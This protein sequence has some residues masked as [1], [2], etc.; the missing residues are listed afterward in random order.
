MKSFLSQLRWLFSPQDKRKFIFI[1][2]LMSLS[3]L[4]ELAGLGVLLAAATVFLSPASAAGQT[5]TDF[6]DRLMPGIQ[7][8][9]RIAATIG[10]IGILLT[11]K[12]LFAFF[13]IH[14]QS[15]FVF[16]KRN[17]M[18]HRIYQKLLHADFES[19]NQLSP[20]FCFN[21]FTRSSDICYQILL[22]CMQLLADI[23]AIAILAGTSIIMFPQVTIGGIIFMLLVTGAVQFM[24]HR[25]NRR[26]GELLL[27]SS[28]E[29]NRLRQAGIAGKKTIKC[30]AKE[31]FF[32]DK[33]DYSYAKTG[34][35]SCKLYTLGQV[36]RL[37]LESAS[38]LLA[39]GV[40]ILMLSNGI[41]KAE[42]LLTFAVLTAA[43]SRI[44]PALSRGHYSLTIIRQYTPQLTVVC[45]ILQN[46]PQEQQ[47]AGE[48]ADAGEDIVFKDVSFAYKNGANVFDKLNLTIKKNS[49][50][51]IA[52]R[53]GRGKSTLIDLLLGLLIP[54]AGSITAGETAI[55]NNLPEWRKQ[56]GIVPQ[57]I[58]LLE[59]SVAENVAFGEEK[60]DIPKVI[61]ALK[62]AGLENLSPEFNITA[63]G[64]L[65]GGQRQRIGIAR[66]L[67]KDIKLLILDEATS[68]L[69]TKTESAFC[70][71]LKTLQG[72][73]TLIVISH[74]ESTLE[75]C[76]QRIDL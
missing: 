37:V 38:A 57:T 3:A 6:L 25:V 23:M 61:Y 33:F 63:Q 43:V 48:C 9:I 58:F 17:E 54:S 47:A 50:L 34:R 73:I 40:F 64:N 21:I 28:L 67:Y 31:Q 46:L 29:E 59:A 74:R 70:D 12:N 24:T 42:I 13:I 39:C 8:D 41:P 30:A 72:K 2:M 7:P 11:A 22:P 15:R 5:V 71:L 52:G 16:A 55:F 44:L 65:S 62:M 69:D 10:I 26:N 68:A 32:L 75:C 35:F 20:D 18:A 51:A 14:I 27:A 1:A 76:A 56:I 45:N 4:L 66:A 19:F 36:P 53:S 60:I 49:S